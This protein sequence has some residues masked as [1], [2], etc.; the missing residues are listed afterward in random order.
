[1]DNA[2]SKQPKQPERQPEAN[3]IRK[4]Q[5]RHLFILLGIAALILWGVLSLFSGHSISQQTTRKENS[6]HFVSPLNHVNE[7]DVWVEKVQNGLAKEQKTT[8]S[9]TQQLQL[10]NQSKTEQQKQ[11]QTQNQQVTQLQTQVKD[12]ENKLTEKNNTHTN[13]AA[14]F[15]SLDGATAPADASGINED[16]LQLT[17]QNLSLNLP[18]TPS[19]NP[20]TYVPAGTFVRAM[21]IGGADTSAGVSSQSNPTP[22][23]FRILDSGTL[24]NHHQ[25]HLKNCFATAA[26]MGDIS[27]ERGQMRL[28][29]L[30]CVG[31]NNQII[32]M[33]VE[34]TVFGPEGKNGVRGVPLWRE[35]A[36]LKRAFVAG[37]LSGIS[38]GI[39][40]QYTTSQLTS[41]GT[42]STINNGDVFRYG[43][44]QGVSNAMDK[45]A[46]YNIRRADQYHPVIQIS[47]GTEVDIVFLK[48][49][50][51]DG[52]KHDAAAEKKETVL[53]PFGM[54]TSQATGINTPQTL[55]PPPTTLPLTPRQIQLLQAQTTQ[56]NNQ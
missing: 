25:S 12:L 5:Q 54:T 1:M 31:I 19:K 7:T 30:S 28:E 26:A 42:S 44:A 39:S 41:T 35:G 48:G 22:V 14:T 16:H 50:Y 17:P 3:T 40:Q 4:S 6:T 20:D 15:P 46:D 29:N 32:D 9:L 52:Q 34:G 56:R 51:L 38:E 45:I 21:M 55:P 24:P 10:L 53:P 11:A 49:F 37:T 2:D 43:A 8:D 27:S 18:A 33:P 23:L 13:N 36:L 47:A